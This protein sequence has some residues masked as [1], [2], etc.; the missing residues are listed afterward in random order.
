[1]L[2]P[3]GG[4]ALDPSGNRRSWHVVRVKGTAGLVL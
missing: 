2:V 4:G 3:P 1:V